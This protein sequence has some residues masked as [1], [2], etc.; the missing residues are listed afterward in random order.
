MFIAYNFLFR[1]D[2]EKL[3]KTSLFFS[4]QDASKY[5]LGDLDK[6]ILK[7][8]PGSELLT[9]THMFKFSDPI[10]NTS[11]PNKKN[12]FSHSLRHAK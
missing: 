6:P 1:R 4:R 11:N 3:K 7:F 5:V 12:I 2:T 9:L 10:E 8:E